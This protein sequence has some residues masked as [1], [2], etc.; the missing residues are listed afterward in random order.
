MTSTS[1]INSQYSIDNAPSKTKETG[2][3]NLGKDAFLQLLMAQL[4]HQD[5]TAP[6][7]NSQFISQMAQFSS[8]EQMQ[9]MTKAVE[10][11]IE[12][13]LQSQLVQYSS[14]IGKKVDWAEITDE[15]DA[16]GNFITNT[17]TNT[18][19]S[20]SYKDGMPVFKLDNDKDI[21]PGNIASMSGGGSS[22]DNSLVQASALIGRTVDYV[23][24]EE[25]K[26]SQVTSVSMKDGKIM[27]S[28][29]DGSVV[30]AGQFTAI[31]QA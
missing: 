7:D 8:L 23:V 24:D 12:V 11:L 22:S 1:E 27:Y 28:L 14:F 20:I 25:T 29:A 19:V 4:Q 18:I 2:N 16:D 30:E 5:P 10:G 6:M 15:K 9:K 17:G 21:T 31:S 13:Q 3:S 26:T